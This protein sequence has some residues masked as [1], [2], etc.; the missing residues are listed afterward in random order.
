MSSERHDSDVRELP[1]TDASAPAKPTTTIE[2]CARCGWLLRAA[3]VAQELL[4]TFENELAG[5]TLMPSPL[6]G[7]FQVRVGEAL[8]WCRKRD[9]GFPQVAELKRRVR[10]HAAPGRP[11]GHTDRESG[12]G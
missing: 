5:V 6:A 2:Y 10:E 7:T 1:A 11:L 4:T 3:W 8:V 12:E 9:G